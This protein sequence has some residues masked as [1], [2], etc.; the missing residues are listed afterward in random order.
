LS[1]VTA[2]S[3][4]GFKFDKIVVTSIDGHSSNLSVKNRG[5][6]LSF[7]HLLLLLDIHF[8]NAEYF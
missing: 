7:I 4:A 8:D 3:W 2:S 5:S 1:L 6:F